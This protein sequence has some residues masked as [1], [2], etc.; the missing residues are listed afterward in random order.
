MSKIAFRL[1]EAEFLLDMDSHKLWRGKTE[2]HLRPMAWDLLSY[3]ALRPEHVVPYAELDHKVWRQDYVSSE[4]RM[5]TVSELRRLLNAPKLISAVPKQG[6]RFEVATEEHSEHPLVQPADRDAGESWDSYG[7]LFNVGGYRVAYVALINDWGKPFLERDLV[8]L[9]INVDDDRYQLPPAFHAAT[10]SAEHFHDWPSCRLAHYSQ[11]DSKRLFIRF[12]ETS[13]RDY[14]IS[15]EHLDDALPLARQQTYRE[16]FGK[17]SREPSGDLRL[18]P[19]TNICGVGMFII[20]HDNYLV[21]TT[22]SESSHVYPGR[23]TFSASGTVRW[24][25]FPDPFSEVLLKA[26]DEINHLVDMRKLH[27]IGFGADARKLYF[28]FSFLERTRSSLRDVINRS[29]K[30]ASLFPIPFAPEQVRD[31][32]LAHCWEPA[33]EAALLTLCVRDFS[34]D[35][36][37]T[38]LATRRS[39]WAVREMRDEWDY[40][41]A[42]PGL[43][44][45]MSVRYPVEQLKGGSDEYLEHAFQFIGPFA[46]KKVLEVGCGTGRF[47]E[48]LLFSAAELTCVELSPRMISR[49]TKRVADALRKAT[50][51]TVV[52]GIAQEHLPIRGNDILICSLVM[53]HNVG[54]AD[55]DR[56]VKGMCESADTIFVFED[57]TEGRKTSP[58]TRLRSA[59]ELETAFLSHGFFPARREH[60]ML[61]SDRIVFLEFKHRSLKVNLPTSQ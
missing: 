35:H 48:R 25:A 46:G 16:E 30:P 59:A 24:G 37:E 41:A 34:R 53:I 14:L 40:R 28:Q 60:H 44:P 17:I 39:S 10:L 54:D 33:A 15:S 22:H 12:Q 4:A 61:F 47:T 18:F 38:T 27:L 19:L 8:D 49:M 2:I 23:K 56:L 6:L 51:L 3:L 50:K 29:P 43:L 13:Y 20:T 7:W 57:I 11:G 58:L 42:R 5:T 1:G 32:L 31:A 36:I 55:F 21:A 26:R 52:A 45:D 9:T